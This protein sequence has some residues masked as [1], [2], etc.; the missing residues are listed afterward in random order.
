M[1]KNLL[2][3]CFLIYLN[4]S[5]QLNVRFPFFSDSQESAHNINYGISLCDSKNGDYTEALKYLKEISVKDNLQNQTSLKYLI[6]FKTKGKKSTFASIDQSIKDSKV[7]DLLKLWLFSVTGNIDDYT[8]A[9]E[10]II[11]KYPNDIQ[12]KKIQI[13]KLLQERYDLIYTDTNFMEL[14]NSIEQFMQENNL[15]D[16]DQLYFKLLKLDCLYY[17]YDSPNI[18]ER[19]KLTREFSKIWKKNP[20]EFHEIYAKINMKLKSDKDNTYF[21]MT[22][23]EEPRDEI[24]ENYIYIMYGFPMEDVVKYNTSKYIDFIKKNPFYYG[25]NEGGF[26][27]SKGKNNESPKHA[28]SMETFEKIVNALNNLKI[29]FPGAI[30]SRYNYLDALFQNKKLVYAEETEIYKLNYLKNLIDI[31][32]LDQTANFTNHFDSFED[33]LE[34]DPINVKYDESYKILLKEV[35]MNNEKEIMDY[36]NQTIIDFPNN[37]NLKYFKSEFINIEK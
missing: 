25:E 9:F 13:R 23:E 35:K 6:D 34:Q 14:S 11:S 32:A 4:Y 36:L 1:K 7:A 12:L 30:G 10:K 20:N 33:I 29:K 21:E 17:Y 8:I 22:N 24:F 31:F 5:A 27:L 37:E 16:E 26:S 19:E 15:S 18:K 3:I 2:F 28:N